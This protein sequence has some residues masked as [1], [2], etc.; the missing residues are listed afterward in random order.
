MVNG[1]PLS[2]SVRS[3]SSLVYHTCQLQCL[4]VKSLNKSVLSVFL[5]VFACQLI[6]VS[7]TGNMASQFDCDR[8]QDVYSVAEKYQMKQRKRITRTFTVF[9]PFVLICGLAIG[10]VLLCSSAF[11]FSWGDSLFIFVVVILR[12]LLC[13]SVLTL[14]GVIFCSS[15]FC[16][17][18]FI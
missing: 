2:I 11:E 17:F 4:L 6:F 7:Y 12:I 9:A 13:S 16:S 15:V 5:L 18:T 14:L 1:Q 10:R 3:L 8:S